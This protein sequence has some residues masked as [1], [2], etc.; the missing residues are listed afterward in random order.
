M[1]EVTLV[2]EHV[3]NMISL[4]NELKILGAVI[5]KESQI[6][7]VLLTLPDSFQQFCLNYN[8]NKMDLSFAKLL[9]ELQVEKSIIKQQA[10]PEALMVDKP[11]SST[12]KMKAEKKKK[13][14]P[15]KVLGAN[16]GVDKPKGKCYYCKQPSHYKKQYPDYI[17]KI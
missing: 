6:E 4:L 13:K 12:S 9:N 5:D 17:A 7:M 14:N 11:S 10:P 3:L 8:M 15:R 16:G 1:V 2:R